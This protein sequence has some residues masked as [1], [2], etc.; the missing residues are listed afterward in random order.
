MENKFVFENFS[1]YLRYQEGFEV[2]EADGSKVYLSPN[3]ASEIISELAKSQKR[4]A[5]RTPKITDL[6]KKIFGEEVYKRMKKDWYWADETEGIVTNPQEGDIKKRDEFFKK[7]VEFSSGLDDIKLSG[8]KEDNDNYRPATIMGFFH[9]FMDKETREELKKNLSKRAN[10][11]KLDKEKI[12]KQITA[13]EADSDTM[14]QPP[15]IL[16]YVDIGEIEKVTETPGKE[17]EAFSLLDEAKQK[18]LFL[19]NSWDLNPQV[20]KELRDQI[21]GVL[22][23]RKAGG[24]SK[25]TEFNIQ[26][27]AS[28]YRNRGKA[29]S[30]SWGQLAFKRSQVVYNMVREILAELQIPEGDPI[31]EELT[32]VAKIDINGSNGDGTSGPNP[33]PDP[34]LGKLRV[35]YYETIKKQNRETEGSS[36]FIDK[37]IA[38]PQQVY[39]TKID[40]FGNSEGTPAV[41]EM[42]V[43]K[44][45]EDYDSFKYVNV[46]VKVIESGIKPGEAPSITIT[47][48]PKNTIAPEIILSRKGKKGENGGD[49]NFKF[50][51]PKFRI[52]PVGFGDLNPIQDLCGGF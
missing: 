9:Q 31:R 38:A 40:G 6:F 20:G 15:A 43:L 27:S 29:E 35:G 42:E 36:K 47:K 49:W 18:T 51:L 30:L 23:R 25:I 33:L 17:P 22:E 50:K 13:K 21:Y 19:D 26:A 10:E 28:R 5:A 48:I 45:K 41:K 32:K 4:M 14:G 39:I 52:I 1:D 7:I 11:L 44:K 16:G 8:S 24:Y 3:D 46:S 37:D 12:L 2:N 34:T